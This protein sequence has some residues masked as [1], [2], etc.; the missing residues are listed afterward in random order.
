MKRQNQLNIKRGLLSKLV[1]LVALLLGSSNA[2]GD[3]VFDGST[4]TLN[5]SLFNGNGKTVS[6]SGGNISSYNTT[7]LGERVII[8][9]DNLSISSG[10]Y[11]LINASK[12]NSSATASF[13]SI[14]F[15]SDNGTNYSDPI[16]FTKDNGLGN[17]Y[18]NL[19]NVVIPNGTNKIKID[20][21]LVN[22][23]SI[24]IETPSLPAPSSFTATPSYNSAS[25]SWTAGGTETKWQIKYNEGEDFNPEEEGTMV[26]DN[27][28]TTKAYTL[29]GLEEGIIYY[30]YIRAYGDNDTYSD[31]VALTGSY[32]TT[33][34]H[35]PRPRNLTL[36]SHTASTATLSWTVGSDETSW[37][38][39]YSTK[40]GFNPDLEGSKIDVNN[41]TCTIS[42]LTDDVTYYA[43]VRSN[44]NG[45][46]SEWSNLV[47]FSLFATNDYNT[48]ASMTTSSNIPIYGYRADSG[49]QSQFIIP[50]AE[51]SDLTGRYI[52]KLTFYTNTVSGKPSNISWGNAT[53]DVYLNMV[54]TEKYDS[55]TKEYEA[56]GT[57]VF[58]EPKKLSVT[59][60]KMEIELDK[61]FL[62]TGN[63]LM[64]GFKQIDTGTESAVEWVA[65][66]RVYGNNYGIYTYLT[67]TYTAYIVPKVNIESV[68]T[69]VPV[70][71]GEN[72]YTTFA[73]PRP[74]DLTALPTGLNAYKAK[75]YADEGKVRF[76]DINQKVAANTGILLAGTANETYNIPFADSSSEVAENDFLVNSTGGTFSSESGYTYFGFLKNSNNPITFA[77]FN[78][79]S[80]AIPT[81]KAYL[82]V[83]T[84]G[85]A[86]QLVA[87][88]DDG[89]TTS[90]RE[91]RNEELGIKNAVF[92]NLNG[93]RVAQPTKGLYI[94]NG[95]KVA[96]K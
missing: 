40:N 12:S 87:V 78:P 95:K 16:T 34:E 6:Y 82:K 2:W 51:L 66:S 73:C 81:N 4:N 69:T 38:I 93:Q 67:T 32:F 19:S 9:P 64:I 11:I 28:V 41:N 31:W 74:L 48:G 58:N 79:S 30:A 37:Q 68:S 89:E 52:K 90:L 42:G 60:Y 3:V 62:Y 49:V 72:G 65:F 75:V 44:Y 8:S 29:S 76:T 91:I 36:N 10:Q 59:D 83:S 25:L 61:P 96:I 22:I 84:S 77:K 26:S 14:Y 56:W 70:T 53:F 20:C 47:A 13:I 35:Y 71:L 80:V 27:P 63:N 43:Y 5:W 54:T 86:R 39:A 33:N 85:E 46:Y 7:G 94:V 21:G 24:T 23:H 92:F 88:F 50:A 55:S 57:N 45:I 18:A 1:L 17:D 15:S